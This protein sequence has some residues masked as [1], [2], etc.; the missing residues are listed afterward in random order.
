MSGASD[1]CLKDTATVDLGI[2]NGQL[3][4]D[5]VVSPDLGNALEK[6]DTGLFLKSG[7]MDAARACTTSSPSIAPGAPVTVAIGSI[8]FASPSSMISGTTVRA[9]K[10]G[11]YHVG[12]MADW[13]AITTGTYRLV[14][15]TAQGSPPQTYPDMQPVPTNYFTLGSFGTGLIELG[16]QGIV[17]LPAG[18][19]L[20]MIAQHDAGG[21]STIGPFSA[22]EDGIEIFLNLLLDL[23]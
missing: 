15:L 9:V 22:Q 7:R 10:T 23:S 3:R 2:D 6:H 13:Q 5:V 1:N 21:A 11:L 19:V 16:F 12:C 4:A 14:A 8:R 18:T 17:Y 20:G